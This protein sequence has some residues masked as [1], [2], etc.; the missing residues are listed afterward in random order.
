MGSIQCHQELYLRA[1]TCLPPFP[2]LFSL[3]TQ[4][5]SETTLT[6]FQSSYKTITK[7]HSISYPSIILILRITIAC[8]R[9]PHKKMKSKSTAASAS[10]TAATAG[11][12]SRSTGRSPK[13]KSN[14]KGEQLYQRLG[15]DNQ[16]WVRERLA[17]FFI[18]KD[19]DLM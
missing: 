15:V 16:R 19:P 18:G 17:L 11:F 12:S 10:S 6:T 13:S 8:E 5:L 14:G 7:L 3:Y 1:P 2:F 4:Y 9:K